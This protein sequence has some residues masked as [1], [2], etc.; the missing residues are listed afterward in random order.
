MVRGWVAAALARV[1]RYYSRLY[2]AA[3]RTM[4]PMEGGRMYRMLM[5]L[6]LTLA[7][8]TCIDPAIQD[9]GVLTDPRPAE[10]SDPPPKTG[11]APEKKKV[12]LDF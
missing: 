5:G 2:V 6:S 3:K 10:R 8:A 12:R 1:K 9:R 4:T 11:D 7:A